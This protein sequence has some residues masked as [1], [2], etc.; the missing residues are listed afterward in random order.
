[1]KKNS[2]ITNQKQFRIEKVIKEKDDKLHLKWKGYNNSFNSW[3]D[4]KHSTNEYIFT[5]TEI[6]GSK[7]KS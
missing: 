1:M 2:K 4:K 5:K 7:Y 3:I 6:F